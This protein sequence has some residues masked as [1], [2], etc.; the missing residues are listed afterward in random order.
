MASGLSF[1]NKTFVIVRFSLL[2]TNKVGACKITGDS[3]GNKTKREGRRE[4]GLKI[5]EKPGENGSVGSYG[6]QCMLRRRDGNMHLILFAP[7]ATKH[8]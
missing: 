1:Q 2:L 3:R 7:R 4:M 5:R 8:V 6:V